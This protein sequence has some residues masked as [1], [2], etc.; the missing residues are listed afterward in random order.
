MRF[1]VNAFVIDAC[2]PY[3]DTVGTVTF[4]PSGGFTN[5]NNTTSTIAIALPQNP[6]AGF[7]NSGNAAPSIALP[8]NPYTCIPHTVNANTGMA[9]RSEHSV[10]IS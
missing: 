10:A 9:S 6:Y 4:S 8:Q 2:S 5:S 1:R 3:A 7:A